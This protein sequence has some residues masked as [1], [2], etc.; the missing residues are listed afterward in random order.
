MRMLGGCVRVKRECN[1]V[2]TAFKT[3]CIWWTEVEFRLYLKH[4]AYGG[5]R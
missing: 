3:H 1:T 5:Q 4:I 2:S